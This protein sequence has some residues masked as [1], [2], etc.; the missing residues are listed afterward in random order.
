MRIEVSIELPISTITHNIYR[1]CGSSSTVRVCGNK[2]AQLITSR[3]SADM[4]SE[5]RQHETLLK[6]VRNHAYS[7]YYYA[8]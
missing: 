1:R 5:Q 8:E 2:T 3:S 7:I 4:H 6:Y